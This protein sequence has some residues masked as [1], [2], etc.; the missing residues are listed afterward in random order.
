MDIEI[1]DAPRRISLVGY[2]G[3]LDGD[4]VAVVG[5][6]LMDKMW[7]E[8]QSLG[9]KTKGINYWVYL[10]DS[11]MFTGI[12]LAEATTAIGTLEPLDVSLERYL[13]H[14]HTGPYS[15][16]PQIWP[17]LFDKLNQQGEIHT[18]PCLEIYGH[19]NQDPSKCE[20]TI[21]IGLKRRG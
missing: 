6:G 20:T 21:L 10:P 18:K 2:H 8:V 3:V 5:K 13:R 16:L 4:S 15:T 17:Q 11:K 12:E 9:L 19:W 7:H 1:I 14:V